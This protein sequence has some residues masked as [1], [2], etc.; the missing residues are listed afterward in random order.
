M[1]TVDTG[2]F[3]ATA[4]TQVKAL[5]SDLLDSEA[6]VT[7]APVIEETVPKPDTMILTLTAAVERTIEHYF[8]RITEACTAQSGPEIVVRGE[9]PASWFVASLGRYLPHGWH[10]YLRSERKTALVLSCLTPGETPQVP[11]K[12]LHAPKMMSSMQA[13][14]PLLLQRKEAHYAGERQRVQ[15]AF[16]TLTR[17]QD[18]RVYIDVPS[19]WPQWFR[20][21]LPYCTCTSDRCGDRI[22]MVV[23]YSG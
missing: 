13:L 15:E 8:E 20:K 11:S 12:G 19:P 6:P 1:S 17:G 14:T 5:V 10:A 7:E 16:A 23:E 9:P 3:M 21:S 4:Y 22:V 2:N 18:L